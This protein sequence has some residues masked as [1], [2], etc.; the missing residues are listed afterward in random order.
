MIFNEILLNF[1]LLVSLSVFSG[2]LIKITCSKELLCKVSQGI[3][4]GFIAIISLFS[5][6]KVQPGVLIDGR[7]IIISLGSYFYGPVS[8][9]IA[10]ILATAG[11]I[12]IG[13]QGML[14]GILIMIIALF[15]GTL[16]YYLKLKRENHDEKFL[17]VLFIIIITNGLSYLT[18]SKFLPDITQSIVS[19]HF[20]LLILT[21][22]STALIMGRILYDQKKAFQLSVNLKATNFLLEQVFN[23][24]F[25]LIAILDKDFN[26][27]RVNKAYAEADEKDV[28]FFPGKNHFDLYPSDAKAIFE[29]VVKTKKPF[30]TYA[31]PFVYADAPERGVTY[32]DW[33]LTPVLNLSGEVDYLIFTLRNV[34]E[35]VRLEETRDRLVSLIESSPDFIGMAD[36]YGKP[37]YLNKAGMKLLEIEK[38]VSLEF[39]S[40]LETH[41]DWSKKVISEIA[42]PE[43]VKNG[44][45]S[46]ETALLSKSGKEI[47]VWQV[48]VAHKDT[49]G[50]VLFYSTI[51]RDISQIKAYEEELKRSE[52]K[53]KLMV[54]NLTN[55]IVIHKKGKFYYV[56]DAALRLVEA[57]SFDQI[58]DIPV[59]E[60]VHPDYRDIVLKRISNVF[61]GKKAELIEEK[62]LTLKGNVR[63]VLVSGVPIIIDG[64]PAS[65]AIVTDITELKRETLINQLLSEISIKMITSENLLEFVSYLREKLSDLIDTKN[66]FLALYDEKKNMLSSP[67]DWDQDTNAPATWSAEGSITGLV[68]K[69]RK[70]LLLKKTEIEEM[71]QKGKIQLIGTLP[72]IWLGVPLVYEDK[73]LGAIVVQSYDKPD[74]YCEETKKLLEIISNYIS[75]YI[76]RKLEE[77]ELRL[78]KKAVDESPISILFTDK[79]G[80]I[81]YVNQTFEKYTGYSKDEAIGKKPSILKS[82]YHSKDYYLNLWATLLNG[83]NFDGEFLNKKKNGEFYWESKAI[84][85]LK[86]KQGEIINFVSFGIDITER[87][88]MM[89]ELILAKERAE[90]ANRIK[91]HFLSAMSHE[92]R[93]PLNPILGFTGLIIEYFER[94]KNEEISRWFNAVQDNTERLIDTTTKILDIEKLEAGEYEMNIEKV[95]LINLINGVIAQFKEKAKGKN[96]ELKSDIRDDKIEMITD[97][98]AVEKILNNLVSNAIKFT[99]QG[100][101]EI[102]V[103]KIYDEV[104]ISVKDTGIGMSED[105]QKFLFEAFSQESSGFRREYEGT[106][107]GL[108]LTKKFINLLKGDISVYS[109]KGEGSIF[110]VILPVSLKKK[111]D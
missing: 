104:K 10:L 45:W 108:S 16:F 48:I 96:I 11:R 31:R 68:V 88:K 35:K 38:D 25:T 36:K 44:V 70:S 40:I 92:I 33:T 19:S 26:F 2:Y 75:L 60:F 84:F 8:G 49:K 62:F 72:E 97:R 91:S 87:K 64:E 39:N 22:P 59:I 58:K 32:W 7:T 95:D 13:G 103:E 86:N 100:F 53:Y 63:D 51:A 4:F 80:V 54:E 90:E 50:E 47:P 29:E 94:Y 109:K 93:T 102:K 28:S 110:E 81:Q 42:L 83:N 9:T 65:M 14:P 17:D 106:G 77:D 41:S 105:Y 73:T 24:P 82:G 71:I 3:L 78:M 79:N 101:V 52:L 30:Q 15:S 5:A 85:P 56:N 67:F 1:F 20:Y 18:S 37:I 34:T 98:I 6:V 111:S 61:Q 46:G 43:V 74:V 23:N 27:I 21:I 69:E 107:L 57:E 55:A 76:Q 99:T 66:F 89:E 12:V